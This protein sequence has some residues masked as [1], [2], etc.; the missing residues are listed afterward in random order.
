MK[1]IV[2]SITQ[3][4]PQLEMYKSMSTPDTGAPEK[5][6]EKAYWENPLLLKNKAFR[7]QVLDLFKDTR[8]NLRDQCW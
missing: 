5:Q 8:F 7:S 4:N 1:L 3:I 2:V 6:T